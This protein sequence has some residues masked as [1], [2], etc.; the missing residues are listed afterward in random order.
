MTHPVRVLAEVIVLTFRSKQ[1]QVVIVN[2]QS[3]E[4]VRR[5]NHSRLRELSG[6][7]DGTSHDAAEQICLSLLEGD[8]SFKDRDQISQFLRHPV[9]PAAEVFC[10]GYSGGSL[11]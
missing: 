3:P 8:A 9:G 7:D 10:E 1:G 4:S 2:R 6:A 11:I 5:G